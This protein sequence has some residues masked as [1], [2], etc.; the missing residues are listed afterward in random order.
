MLTS[1]A[2]GKGKRELKKNGGKHLLSPKKLRILHNYEKTKAKKEKQQSPF[3]DKG[4]KGGGRKTG[5]DIPS[6]VYAK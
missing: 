6:A 2:R 1:S 4:K 5:W 3:C